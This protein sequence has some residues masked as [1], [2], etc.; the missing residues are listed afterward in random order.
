M[1]ESR[2]RHEDGSDSTNAP[3]KSRLLR[4]VQVAPLEVEH[5]HGFGFHTCF[6]FESK[7]KDTRTL[8]RGAARATGARNAIRTVGVENFRRKAHFGRL[9][10]VLVAKGHAQA[11]N[12]A[13]P[14]RVGWPENCRRPNKNVL[15]TE[16]CCTCA[17]PSSI[18]AEIVSM[19]AVQRACLSGVDTRGCTDSSKLARDSLRA[20]ATSAAHLWGILLH[21]AEITHE[22]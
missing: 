1:S 6:G 21:L 20:S 2:L 10:R 22:A 15:L 9:V 3:P 13:L 14:W 5:A 18:V 11:E 12:A 8:K 7:T 17:L 16:W 19:S 4:T